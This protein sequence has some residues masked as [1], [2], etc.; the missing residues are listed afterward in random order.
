[1]YFQESVFVGDEAFNFLEFDFGGD[2]NVVHF[3]GDKFVGEGDMNNFFGHVKYFDISIL[4]AF[5]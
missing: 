3:V 1:M 4:L 2:L 5:F